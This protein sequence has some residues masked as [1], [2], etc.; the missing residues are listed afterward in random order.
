MT[1]QTIGDFV[2]VILDSLADAKPSKDAE[3]KK[4]AA[5]MSEVVKMFYRIAAEVAGVAMDLENHETYARLRL[6]GLNL[7]VVEMADV[8]QTA[9]DE[10]GVVLPV[11]RCLQSMTLAAFLSLMVRTVTG[12]TRN[13]ARKQGE[14]GER[15]AAGHLTRNQ[16]SFSDDGSRRSPL[17]DLRDGAGGSHTT[18]PSQ[19]KIVA[20]ART[21]ARAKSPAQT[22]SPRGES[23]RKM[24][25]PRLGQGG[26]AQ[27]TSE[28]NM[29]EHLR[30]V[31]GAQ[32]GQGGESSSIR[33]NLRK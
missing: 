26:G 27:Q 30:L 9:A 24:S 21:R 4:E 7:T 19:S 14:D 10:L 15:R 8:I 22:R 33:R 31:K 18:T 17:G 32:G 28:V 11:G 1:L 25:A 13:A 2:I 23:E 20:T 16:H 29:H 3:Q 12:A 5:L 6:D